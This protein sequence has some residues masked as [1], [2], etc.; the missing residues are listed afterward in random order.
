MIA[1]K[2]VTEQPNLPGTIYTAAEEC[3]SL[4]GGKA[5]PIQMDLRKEESVQAAFDETISKFGSLDI[6]VNNASAIH[7]NLL[8]LSTW[9]YDL[10][11]ING[12]GTFSYEISYPVFEG[13]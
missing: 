7:M 3:E 11:I 13:R 8:K 4:G 12:R 2:T 5:L 9:R 6:L 10:C 1:A